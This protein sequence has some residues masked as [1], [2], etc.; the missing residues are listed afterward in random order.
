MVDD[1]QL[2]EDQQSD[3]TCEDVTHREFSRALNSI[4]DKLKFTMEHHS[5]FSGGWLP[6]L[7]FSVNMNYDTNQ[8]THKYY[9]KPMNT[10]QTK[11]SFDLD[12]WKLKLG[13]R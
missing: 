10:S 6:T 9:K 1:Q 13:Q 5:D 2:E 8:F 4:S 12:S 11:S 3:I 7:D